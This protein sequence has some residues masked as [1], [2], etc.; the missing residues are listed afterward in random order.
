MDG[1]AGTLGP[2]HPI[3]VHVQR[4]KDFGDP[5]G[6]IMVETLDFVDKYSC[7]GYC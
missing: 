1:L 2:D 7:L 4:T 3:T 5:G 6:N